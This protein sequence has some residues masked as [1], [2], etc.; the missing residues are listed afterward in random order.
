MIT[1]AQLSGERRQLRL[2]RQEPVRPAFDD[3]PVHLFG[4]DHTAGAALAFE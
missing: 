2:A 3:E 1:D 4:H